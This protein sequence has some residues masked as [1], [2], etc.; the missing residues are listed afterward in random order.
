MTRVPEV[1]DIATGRDHHRRG[2]QRADARHGE[3][4]GAGGRLIGGTQPSFE[5]IRRRL[6]AKV[7]H[8]RAARSAQALRV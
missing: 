5:R 7:L 4:R 3:Q 8:P 1:T 2:S 6:S